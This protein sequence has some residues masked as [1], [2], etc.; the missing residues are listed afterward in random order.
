MLQ[1]LSTLH[2]HVQR[3]RRRRPA[4]VATLQGDVDLQDALAMSLLVATQAAIDIAFHVC[5]DEGWGI[6]DS[7]ADAFGILARRSVLSAEL[8]ERLRR[9]VAVRNRIAHLYGTV[10]IER[11]W[12]E[13]PAGLDALEHLAAGIAAFLGD[14][15]GRSV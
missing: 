14:A 8:A 7:Y 15:P 10:D 12:S 9:V 2:D 1:L 6:P 5:T 11:V 4:D 3:A 13:L